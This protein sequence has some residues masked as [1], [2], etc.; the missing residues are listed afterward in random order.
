MVRGEY[1]PRQALPLVIGSDGVGEIVEIGPGVQRV[2]MGQR[3]CPNFM[4]TWQS[5]EPT[6]E[7]LRSSLGGPI[8][9]TL[10]EY[11]LVDADSLVHVP[12][13]LSDEEAA[14]LPCAG[15]TAW[16]AL[17]TYG[18]ASAGGTI[19]TQ[20]TGGVSIFALQLGKLLGMRVIA[21]SS[22]A[23]K[24]ERL[25]AL[26]AD[27]VINY[28]EDRDWGNSARKLTGGVG[29]DQVIEVAGGKG[30]VESVR[31]TRPGGQISVIGV[32]SGRVSDFNITPVLMQN[33]RLQGITVGHRDGFAAMN[34]ALAL[35]RTR[36]IVDR[37]FSLSEGRAA[38]EYLASGAHFGKICIRIA[39]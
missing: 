12:E 29:V 9:G 2:S 39:G 22:S 35:H 15:L 28:A 10:A 25:R 1:N 7:R 6:R 16:S 36:P 11:M 26:G 23:D 20:G 18:N 13:Y 14:C 24:L 19:L 34:R 37:V 31:A 17:V 32:L 8:D 38:L 27:D 5:G 4:Q 3:V 21:T 30:L 33:I